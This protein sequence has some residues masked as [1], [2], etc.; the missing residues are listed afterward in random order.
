MLQ[1][2]NSEVPHSEFHN[3]EYVPNAGFI[4]NIRNSYFSQRNKIYSDFKEITPQSSSLA[5]YGSLIALKKLLSSQHAQ[6][7]RHDDPF[8][9]LFRNPQEM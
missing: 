8:L 1:N 5:N 2:N 4:S 9:L 3:I 7:R 6:D